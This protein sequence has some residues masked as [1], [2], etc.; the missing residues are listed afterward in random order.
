VGLL[1]GV[2]VIILVAVL[3]RYGKP[4]PT[5]LPGGEF[6]RMYSFWGIM[7]GMDK[8]R[9]SVPA[10]AYIIEG[11]LCHPYGTKIRFS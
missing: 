7:G 8:L 6:W 3:I 1:V 4:T 2:V 10:R 11:G 5:P 9:L